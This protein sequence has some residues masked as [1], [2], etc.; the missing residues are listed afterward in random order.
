MNVSIL[1]AVVHSHPVDKMLSRAG[2]Q[3]PWHSTLEKMWLFCEARQV[4][5]LQ[6]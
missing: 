6:E 4:G 5:C 2:V 1:D 3:A